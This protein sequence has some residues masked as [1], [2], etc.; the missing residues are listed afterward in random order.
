MSHRERWGSRFSFILA[1]VGSAVG[2]GNI[3]KFPYIVGHNGAGA[4]VAVYL[5]CICCIGVPLLM[6]E[7]FIGARG[8][9]GA[10]KAF[11]I[12]HRDGS[13]WRFLGHLGWMIAFII[14]SFYC[15]IGGWILDFLQLA[16]RGQ[17]IYNN[18]DAVGNILQQLFAD[19]TRQIVWHGVFIVLNA[20]V[21]QRGFKKGLEQAGLWLM[22]TLVFVLLLL[23]ICALFLPGIGRAVTFLFWP[24][25]SRLT[26]AGILEAVGH[27]FFTLSIAMGIMLTY[28]SYL[29]STTSL[30]RLALCIALF[31]T[32]IALMVGVVIFS[33]IFSFDMQANSGPTLVFQTLPVLFS[34]LAGGWVISSLFFL[35]VAFAALTSSLSLFE[36]LISLSTETL[37]T[38]RKKAALGVAIG[39]FA[40][41]IVSALSTNML[42]HVTVWGKT[43]FD[44]LDWLTSSVLLPVSGMGFALFFGWV[45]GAPA[46]AELLGQRIAQSLFGAVFLWMVRV[47]VPGA[48]C[49]VWLRG[50]LY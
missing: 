12:V 44:L 27:S 9:A 48:I 21:M 35:L 46:V 5:L 11:E 4:F 49:I 34:Q 32:L 18:P 38:S 23:L 3:W 19:P 26:A 29:G 45:L 17:L 25:T 41:G 31:D 33:V 50:L 20:V 22:P 2:L 1:S 30:G 14:L 10:V 28:G 39:A 15:V 7:L 13:P 40:L 16:V 6:C 24:D 43:P 8:Q 42:A 37:E 36:L 47:V